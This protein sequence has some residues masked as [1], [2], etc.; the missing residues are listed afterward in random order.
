MLY[1]LQVEIFQYLASPQF[2]TGFCVTHKLAT[3]P[4]SQYPHSFKRKVE[5]TIKFEAKVMFT[6]DLSLSKKIDRVGVTTTHF[7]D[8]MRLGSFKE[9]QQVFIQSC[10]FDLATMLQPRSEFL[11][12]H[13]KYFSP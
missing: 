9:C 2:S 7:G 3:F 5:L 1:R 13:E 12:S 4:T 6:S 8:K 11:F 10:T